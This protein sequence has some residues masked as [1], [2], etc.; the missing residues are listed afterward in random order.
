MVVL[1]GDVGL[2]LGD[3]GVGQGD[4]ALVVEDAA[5]VAPGVVVID[6]GVLGLDVAEVGDRAAVAGSAVAGERGLLEHGVA[7]PFDQ[8]PTAV[9]PVVVR[10]LGRRCGLHRRRRLPVLVL[11]LR[12]GGGAALDD[13]VLQGEI[14]VLGDAE[15]PERVLRV[16]LDRRAVTLD[17]DVLLD[18]RQARAGLLVEPVQFVGAVLGQL[19]RATRVPV[20]EVEGLDQ[21]LLVTRHL[22]NLPPSAPPLALPSGRAWSW[23]FWSPLGAPSR[24]ICWVVD[25]FRSVR[26]VP[27]P[28]VVA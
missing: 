20:G 28:P 17:G 13:E 9:R 7:A 25:R 6:R 26:W 14:A 4:G 10:V 23:A 22:L 27:L 16:P 3:R 21:L 12:L 11:P 24:V 19:E 15:D 18:G 2:V 8:Q 5:A 1:A